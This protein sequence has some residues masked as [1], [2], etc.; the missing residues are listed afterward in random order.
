MNWKAADR[1]KSSEEIFIHAKTTYLENS[2][3]EHKYSSQARGK[4]DRVEGW[5][6]RPRLCTRP[7]ISPESNSV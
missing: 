6:L 3:T 1:I 5:P 4:R 7:K 2:G